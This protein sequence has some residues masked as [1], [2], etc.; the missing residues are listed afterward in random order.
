MAPRL[1]GLDC[2]LPEGINIKEKKNCGSENGWSKTK[3]PK[4]ADSVGICIIKGEGAW[5]VQRGSAVSTTE[6]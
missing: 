4:E 2:N 5:G 1:V 3:D 6:T